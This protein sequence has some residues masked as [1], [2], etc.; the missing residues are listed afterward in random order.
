MIYISAGLYAEGR[1][2]Y[3]FLLP[4][5]D[6]LLEKLSA[7]LFPGAYELADTRGI[8][9]SIKTSGRAERIRS[10]VAEHIDFC[11]IF[12]IHADGAG[13]PDEVRRTQINPGI[14]L[15]RAAVPR[16]QVYLITCVPVH[17][18]EAWMLVDPRPFELVLGKNAPIALPSQPETELDPKS[19]LRKIF[20]D[21]DARIP[22][23]EAYRFLGVNVTLEKLRTLSAFRAFEQELRETLKL[24]AEAQGWRDTT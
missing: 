12:V 16:R 7:N 10:A 9:A 3:D 24:L 13:D 14:D 22:L 19:V 1:S 23:K 17:E 21:G 4:L 8:D 5:I 18:I 20:R 11:D 6:R 15:I 2:D